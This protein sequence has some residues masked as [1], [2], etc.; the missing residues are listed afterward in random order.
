MS[1]V[2][3]SV[4]VFLLAVAAIAVPSLAAP[5]PGPPAAVEDPS[6][7]YCPVEEGS[8][9]ATVVH[10]A[11][12][13]SGPLA[14]ATFTSGAFTGTAETEIGPSGAASVAIREVAAL[15][16]GASIL[17]L[18]SSDAGATSL[19]GGS[20]SLSAETCPSAPAER[21]LLGG[22]ST[23]SGQ[24]FLVQLMNPYAGEAVADLVIE[25]DAGLE[26]NSEL[27]NLIV[28]ARSSVVIDLAEM[29]PGRE[30][31]NVAIEVTQGGAF[32]VGRFALGEDEA[33][34]NALEPAQDWY[35]TVP[36]GLDSHQV[37]IVADSSAVE[38]QI[39]IYTPDG[40]VE[41]HG[42][43]EIEGQGSGGLRHRSGDACRLSGARRF[44]KPGL[45]VPPGQQRNRARPHRRSDD[46]CAG[47][48]PP[49]SRIALGGEQ[50][51]GHPQPRARGR[52][53]FSGAPRG[54]GSRYRSRGPGG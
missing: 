1:R 27:E 31:M 19:I 21:A 10:A 9:R 8:G 22:G 23:L 42:E 45:G 50:R 38:Y 12:T 47:V 24:S 2:V 32:A 7:A 51:A 18:P 49:R 26:S 43:G 34:W 46:R 3:A 29:L 54:R 33:L 39:D 28:P 20:N 30:W 15:G 52:E 48:A 6:V 40:L 16:T 5:E 17:E 14:L 41:G 13:V 35:L 25:S 36:H 4:L 44:D 11:S 37:V 53:R